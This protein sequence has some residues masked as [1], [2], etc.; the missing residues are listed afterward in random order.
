MIRSFVFCWGSN[1]K[2]GFGDNRRKLMQWASW[3]RIV[4]EDRGGGK[5]P[6][7]FPPPCTYPSNFQNIG[8]MMTKLIFLERAM[9]FWFPDNLS[10]GYTTKNKD[11]GTLRKKFFIK[12]SKNSYILWLQILHRISNIFEQK[13]KKYF[14]RMVQTFIYS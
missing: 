1:G 6:M 4:A 14:F 5:N 11:F 10:H 12:N 3:S 7:F 8:R 9:H 13:I 2:F